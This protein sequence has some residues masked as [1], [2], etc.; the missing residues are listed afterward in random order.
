MSLFGTSGIRMTEDRL[1]EKF[2]LELGK[3]LGS[4]AD[5]EACAVGRDTRASGPRIQEAFVS[6]VLSTGVNVV[7]AGIVSTPTLGV[8]TAE[9]GSGVMVTASHNP[10]EYNGFKF[11]S[12]QGALDSDSEYQLEGVYREK[13]FVS[14]QEGIYW[15]QDFI[16]RH[17]ELII[18]KTGYVGDSVRVLVDCAGGAGSTITPQLLERMGASVS[19]INT[20]Q[21]GVFP[22]PL[23]PSAEN[24]EETCRIVREGDFDIAFAHDGDADR[25]CAIDSD[26]KLI[27]WDSFLSVLAFDKKRVVTTVDA[28]MRL[29]EVCKNVVITAVGDVAVAQA[30]RQ[31]DA[32]FGGEPSGT[33]IFPDVH[34]FPD[35]VATIAK[36]TKM[37]SD[38]LFYSFLHEI[39]SYPM[40]RVKVP[41]RDEAKKQA[42]IS[43]K[44]N[45]DREYFDLDGV[46]VEL[47]EGWIL[48]RPSGTEPFIRITCEAKDEKKL[49]NYVQLGTKWVKS[50]LP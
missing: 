19:A 38:G 9:Y 18:S 27:E 10:P 23:E 45:L 24:L 22:H 8:A 49:S 34:I 3:A 25:A 39:P 33:F 13:K 21:D 42:M 26:G 31:Y 29:N 2:N 17:A 46:R 15:E 44:K 41:C 20:S 50:A 14:R 1:T 48:I 7:K 16:E 32:D 30:V 12:P 11:F 28:S 47:D 37:V 35:G 43:L 4:Y 5:C 36:A 40:Q 6:G